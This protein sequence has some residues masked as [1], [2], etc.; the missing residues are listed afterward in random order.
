MMRL[1]KQ[2]FNPLYFH[3]RHYVRD[4]NIRKIMVYGGKS[5]AKTF[6]ISQLFCILCENNGLSS[7]CYRK[8]QTTIKTTLKPAFSK[9]IEKMFLQKA[10]RIMDFK[11]ANDKGS[12]IIFKGL[13]TEGK[14]KGIEGFTYLLFDEI[15]Q[16]E[17]EEWVQANLSLRGLPNQK[18]FATWNPVDENIWIKKELDRYQWTALPNTIEGKPESKL[19]DYSRIQQSDDGKIL[20]IKTTYHD[21]AWITGRGDIPRDQNLI[22]EYES[23]K[24]VDFN[25]YNVNVL[26][27]WG[28]TEKQR[29]FAWAYD[30][31][32]Q[33]G[34]CTHLYDKERFLW[35]SFD[36]NVNPISCT[37]FQY[38][39]EENLLLGI[40]CFKLANSNITEL[41]DRILATYPDALY[42]VTGD[43]TGLNRSALVNENY[44]Y[45][46]VICNKLN[47]S[48]QSRVKLPSVNPP[49]SENH[50][51]CNTVLKK[52]N[53]LFDEDNCKELHYDM[54]YVEMD[55]NKKLIKD[56]ST[57]KKNADFLDHFRY[58][59]NILFPKI[60]ALLDKD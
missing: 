30:P 58:L 17:Q 59:C 41:C 53:C 22:D 45:Y 60:K 51:L 23:L 47:I 1:R 12:N 57:D 31:K 37:A 32:L 39:E 25:W 3:L 2:W 7:I 55:E 38:Y 14:V 10:F 8:E 5:S 35:L 48:F 19:S 24:E 43:A 6:S 18:L 13:D 34:K 33:S 29:K 15:D 44:N 20:L 42:M 11:I 56:R 46:T 36:F 40:K 9:A 49:I 21:N 26:G 54:M 16:F 27:E 4:P 28:I 50:L 52:V